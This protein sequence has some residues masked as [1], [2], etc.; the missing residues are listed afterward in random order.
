MR[1][2][3]PGFLSPHVLICGATNRPGDKAGVTAL[4]EPLRSRFDVAFRIAT[5]SDTT[6]DTMESGTLLS[7]WD[8]ELAGWLDWM[9][10]NGAPSELVAW[11]QFSKGRTAYAW[12]PNSDPS[13]RMADYRSWCTVAKLWNSG[14]KSTQVIASAIGKPAAMEFL[15]FASL[16]DELPTLDEI[17][18]NPDSARIPSQPA[19]LFL[20]SSLLASQCEKRDVKPIVR[21]FSRMP[22]T[23]GAL[24]GRSLYKRLAEKLSASPEWAGWIIKNQDLFTL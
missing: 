7:S 3:D 13:I 9:T 8:E 6:T 20:V 4:C 2:F 18:A 12:K 23:Y 24:I 21:Y 15:G 11:H 17:R 22:R 1:L 14:H 19:S 10:D 16:A 5:P